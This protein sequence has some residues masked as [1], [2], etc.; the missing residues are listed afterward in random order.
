MTELFAFKALEL[1]ISLGIVYGAYRIDKST[2]SRAWELFSAIGTI[3]AVE[4]LL[5]IYLI[6]NNFRLGMLEGMFA[7]SIAVLLTGAGLSFVEEYTNFG[8]IQIHHLMGYVLGVVGGSLALAFMAPSFLVTT[9]FYLGTPLILLAAIYLFYRMRSG[10]ETAI[11]N[12][13]IASASLYLLASLM[14]I[15]LAAT[16]GHEKYVYSFMLNAAVPRVEAL[17]AFSASAPVMK[18]AGT[19]FL[20][21]SVYLFYHGVFRDIHS[22]KNGEPDSRKLADNTVENIGAIIGESLANRMA[23]EALNEEF[24]KDTESI[25]NTV[26]DENFEEVEKALKDKF[27][28]TVGPVA[29]RKIEEITE[30][31]REE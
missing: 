13:L 26:K 16:G 31:I 20:G 12:S 9:A 28:D 24:G 5:Q 18:M 4:S 25:E 2:N 11:F 22:G 30:E 19:M 27:G 14:N 17:T 3:L 29:E 6:A 1:L 21:Y 10:G 8:K 15:Y 23:L 7:P